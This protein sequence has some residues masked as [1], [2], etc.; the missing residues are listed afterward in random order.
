MIVKQKKCLFSLKSFLKLLESTKGHREVLFLHGEI[1]FLLAILL[2]LFKPRKKV[3]IIFYYGLIDQQSL[4]KKYFSNALIL[5]LKTLNVLMFQLELDPTLFTHLTC[6]FVTPL[7]DPYIHTFSKNTGEDCTIRTPPTRFLVAGFLDSRKCIPQIL[8]AL[9][10]YSDIITPAVPELVLL[11]EESLEIQE[12]LNTKINDKKVRI[13]SKN[14]R[15]DDEELIYEFNNTDIVMAIYRNHHGS[16]GIVINSIAHHKP[17]LFIPKGILKAFQYQLCI[18]QLPSEA[19]S[20]E[21]LK[22]IVKLSDSYPS[23]Y[24]NANRLNFLAG[25]SPEE[26]ATRLLSQ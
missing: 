12:Y 9:E 4:F 1:Q 14:Y 17:V 26:F 19:T 2:R 15:F 22:N 25:R 13:I 11:G 23:Q 8:E 5:T 7:K 6:R 24:S 20:S 3:K 21:I 16:S 10:Q 18:S